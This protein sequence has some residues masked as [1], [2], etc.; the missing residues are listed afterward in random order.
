MAD[1]AIK[2][3][4]A[5]GNV[6]EG[7]LPPDMAK[8]LTDKAS[9]VDNLEQE[10]N[11]FRDKD[12]NFKKYREK[13]KDEQDKMRSE[14]SSKERMLLDEIE[15]LRTQ[16]GAKDE[17]TLGA[18]R[19]T[20]LDQLSGGDKD[21]RE[22]LEKEYDRLPGNP[23][24]AEQIHLK[25]NEANALLNYRKEQSS[26]ASPFS[27]FAPNTVAPF[28]SPSLSNRKSYADT[29]EGESLAKELGLQTK[30]PDKK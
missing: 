2:L 3:Y 1:D 23:L 17:A 13:T 21:F 24:T 7:A 14:M 9:K 11:K 26:H 5:D 18:A 4:D 28:S 10:L 29:S 16:I 12:F 8:E 30:G 15:D 22:Q 6:V 25:M 20:L 19:N 27:V